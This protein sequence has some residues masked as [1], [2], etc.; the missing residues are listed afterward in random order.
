MAD[1]GCELCAADTPAEWVLTYQDGDPGE[2]RARET[3]LTVGN[4]YLATRG[5]APEAVADAHHYPGTYVAGIYNRLTSV[6]DGQT[7]EDESIVN[8]PNWLP[9]TF[10]PVR[11]RWFAPGVWERAHEHTALEQTYVIEGSLE[12][13][14]GQ[15]GP[16]QFVWRP[17][18]NRHE[19]LSPNGAVLLGFFLKPNRFAYGEKFFTA[20]GEQ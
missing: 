10:R 17:A 7:R 20:A 12:D 3:M 16:G 11:G 2:E 1:V 9:V 6:V 8:L 5:A 15:C 13:H 4:G 19:A 14:E 18:G